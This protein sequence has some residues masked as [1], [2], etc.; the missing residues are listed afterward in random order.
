VSNQHLEPGP[1][2]YTQE[3][4]E[5]TEDVRALIARLIST[6][7]T[8]EPI[9]PIMVPAGTNTDATGASKF[10]L[11][12]V[13]AGMGL[14]VDQI[15][16]EIG[17]AA[18]TPAAPITSGYVGVYRGEPGFGGLIDF[19]P[20]VVGQNVAPGKMTDT[21]NTPPILRGERLIVVSAGLPVAGQ[22]VQIH[23]LLMGRLV[24]L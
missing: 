2:E 6:A 20:P 16:I 24:K 5:T 17:G 22:L 3:L 13:P 18:V 7:R 8:D 12:E 1:V 10:L 14:Y 11:Y 21:G 4:D 23:A 9:R 15:N 19:L